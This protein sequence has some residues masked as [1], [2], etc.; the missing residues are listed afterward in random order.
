MH[1]QALARVTGLKGHEIKPGK[2]DGIIGLE[3]HWANKDDE[4]E[5]MITFERGV[6]VYASW[7]IWN[8]S[9]ENMAKHFKEILEDRY[10]LG[11]LYGGNGHEEAEIVLA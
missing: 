7:Y 5:A 2:I 6:P 4:W 9:R 10:V 8:V 11:K 1:N 3:L